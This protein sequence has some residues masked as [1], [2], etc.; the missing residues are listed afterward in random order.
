MGIEL[1]ENERA[2]RNFLIGIRNSIDDELC[3]LYPE[4]R[5]RKRP[6]NATLHDVDSANKYWIALQEE[7]EF[8]LHW[9]EN[10]KLVEI[11]QE[12]LAEHAKDLERFI[13]GPDPKALCYPPVPS[14]PELRI[15]LGLIIYLKNNLKNL[16][17]AIF[18]PG[19]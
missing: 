4:K 5:C 11:Y 19:R 9:G 14:Q 3:T 13:D 2:L 17:L 12:Q 6:R 8:W 16:R 7:V 18:G 15:N 1:P 10:G